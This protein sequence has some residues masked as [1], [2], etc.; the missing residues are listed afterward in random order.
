[1]LA[2]AGGLVV[3]TVQTADGADAKRVLKAPP[4]RGGR[5]A[6]DLLE[7]PAERRLRSMADGLSVRTENKFHA[8]SSRPFGALH[9]SK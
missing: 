8:L 3:S 2:A 9:N 5:F 4:P 1:L 7:R 6:G